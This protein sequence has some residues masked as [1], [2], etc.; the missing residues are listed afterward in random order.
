[1]TATRRPPRRLDPDALAALEEERDFLLRSLADLDAEHAA[2]DIDDADYEALKDDYT[3]RAAAAIRGID[4]QRA[5]FAAQPG[6]RWRQVLVWLVGLAV[7]GGL[8]GSLIARTSGAR[9]E[10]DEATGGLRESTI[11]LLN[12]A[13]SLLGQQDR[14]DDAIDLYT[15]VLDEQPSN[16]EAITYRAWLQYRS[17]EPPEAALEAWNEALLLDPDATEAAVFE[18]IVLSDLGRYDEAAEALDGIDL[19]NAP[20]EIAGLVQQRGIVGEVYGESRFDLLDERDEAPGPRR[21]RP[22]VDEALAA[23]GYLVNSGRE[24]GPVAALKL[25]EAITDVDPTNPAALSRRALILAQVGE[26]PAAAALLDQAVEANPD[27][28]EALL[29]RASFLA[30]QR[31]SAGPGHGV[32]RSRSPGGTRRCAGPAA[33]A[34]RGTRR[35]DLRLNPARSR[36]VRPPQRWTTATRSG[37]WSGAAEVAA[38]EDVAVGGAELPDRALLALVACEGDTGGGQ[39]V[40]HE[41]DHVAVAAQHRRGSGG[42]QSVDHR[43]D[44]P[45]TTSFG[46]IGDHLDLD[47][48]LGCQRLDR[49]A[50]PQRR[51]GEDAF[52]PRI[53]ERIDQTSGLFVALLVE[54]PLQ[55]GDTAAAGTGARVAHEMDGHGCRWGRLIAECTVAPGP[56]LDAKWPGQPLR[57]L[58]LRTGTAGRRPLPLGVRNRPR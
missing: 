9:G 25:F 28:P 1:V 51:A 50:A 43:H 6:I 29:S 2:G 18:I 7:L 32:W 42:H 36:R 22:V 13:R 30:R 39:G 49:L 17:G 10:N 45:C 16:T 53:G 55:I 48:Q 26:A 57:R 40:E 27:D 23:A 14:W 38:F 54:R 8:S 15:E 34:G 31:R 33:R 21:A 3:R 44:R 12:Q 52:D 41:R 20:P 5:A 37:W 4:D 47:T 19:A 24:G 58:A 56:V 35:S 11:T 46:E